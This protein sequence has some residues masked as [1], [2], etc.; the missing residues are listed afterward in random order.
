MTPVTDTRH[1]R[2]VY[3]SPVCGHSDSQTDS[4]PVH[5]MNTCHQLLELHVVPFTGMPELA[6]ERV[7][8]FFIDARND[9][10]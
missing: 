6:A 5:D 2:L 1:A 7:V 10:E 3:R 9:L 8:G 4:M